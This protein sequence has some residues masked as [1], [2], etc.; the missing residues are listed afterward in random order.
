MFVLHR[1]PRMGTFDGKQDKIRT[2]NPVDGK[3][4]L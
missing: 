3:I 4:R 2:K 1:L